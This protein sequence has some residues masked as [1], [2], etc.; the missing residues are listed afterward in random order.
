[1]LRLPDL[2]LYFPVFVLLHNSRQLIEQLKLQNTFSHHMMLKRIQPLSVERTNHTKATV[3][4]SFSPE[5]LNNSYT[6]NYKIISTR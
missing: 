6:K 1:M 3:M 2:R 4:I 5:Q